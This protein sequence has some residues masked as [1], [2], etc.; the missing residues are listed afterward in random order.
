[1]ADGGLAVPGPP[2]LRGGLDDCLHQLEQC[3]DAR[4]EVTAVDLF[5]DLFDPHAEC[6]GG[7]DAELVAGLPLEALGRFATIG[8]RD[9]LRLDATV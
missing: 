5:R 6:R 9:F 2:R 1:M 3:G 4:G 7:D 8:M